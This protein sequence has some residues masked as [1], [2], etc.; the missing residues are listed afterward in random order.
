[1]KRPDAVEFPLVLVCAP[2]GT[3]LSKVGEWLDQEIGSLGSTALVFDLELELRAHRYESQQRAA[4]VELAAYANLQARQG[5][6]REQSNQFE[7]M[8]QVLDDSRTRLLEQWVQTYERILSRVAG[9]SATAIPSFVALFLHLTWYDPRTRELF[10]PVNI[11]TLFRHGSVRRVILLIDDVF[12]MFSSL[13]GGGTED[14]DKHALYSDRNLDSEARILGKL[15]KEPAEP[16]QCAGEKTKEQYRAASELYQRRRAIEAVEVAL[17]Q[18][19]SWRRSE[20]I[21]AENIARTLGAEFTLLGTK[22]SRGALRLLAS[23]SE[24]HEIYLSHRISEVRRSKEGDQEKEGEW[25]PLVDEVNSLHRQFAEDGCILVSPTAIDELRFGE[26]LAGGP[27]PILTHRWPL[28]EGGLLWVPPGRG[29]HPNHTELLRGDL[30]SSDP[31]ALGSARSLAKQILSE[32]AAR[33]HMIVEHTRGLCV[34]RPFFGSD[35]RPQATSGSSSGT[36]T[37]ELEQQADS[38]RPD[39]PKSR[40]SGGVRREL[41]HWLDQAKLPGLPQRRAAFVHTDKEI[42]ARLRWFKDTSGL[43]PEAVA[44]VK[45]HLTRNLI[46]VEISQ[47]L[48]R[49]FF[50]GGTVLKA[51]FFGGRDDEKLLDIAP[52]VVRWMRSCT[53]IALFETFARLDRPEDDADETGALPTFAIGLFY[54][55][56]NQKGGVEDLSK[57]SAKLCIFFRSS[58]SGKEWNEKFWNDH[59]RV[60]RKIFRKDPARFFADELNIAYEEFVR[61]AEKRAS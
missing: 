33:D 46:D 44:T 55:E 21:Q 23:G 45:N 1:M 41:E 35:R 47:E 53:A 26:A 8:D 54:T 60:F 31:I 36:P 3:G 30:K 11:P 12:D 57:L 4:G 32:V 42:A 9:E 19:L 13:R 28:P 14:Q 43:V 10:S 20:M 34:Y 22:H 48:R 29:D 37:T 56:E 27:S 25:P 49:V 61:E 16:S 38:P 59:D 15:W 17:T 24:V 52:D 39:R 2:S 50:R 51:D 5:A 58:A 40:W 18:L 7:R 6:L